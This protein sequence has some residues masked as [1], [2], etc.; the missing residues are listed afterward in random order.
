MLKCGLLGE[1]LGHSYSPMIHAQLADYSYQLYERSPEQLTPFLRSTEWDGLNVTI[2]YKK[3][4]VPYCDELS[5]QARQLGSVNTL[6]RLLGGRLYGDN[7]DYYGF[8]CLVNDSGIQVAGRSAIVLG[9]GGA[10]VTVCAVLHA[11]G[12]ESVTVISRSG[13]DNYQNLDRH[14]DAQIVVNTTPLGMYPNNGEAAVD[15]RRFPKCEGVF[16]LIYNPARTALLLQAEELGIPC[17]CGL[18][19]LVAQAVR[20]CERFTGSVID[21]SQIDEI[22]HLM[23]AQLQNIVLIGMPGCGKSTVAAALGKRLHRPVYESDAMVE[24]R[25]GMSIS[26]IFARSGEDRFRELESEV[27]SELGKLTGAVISTG[28]GCVTRTENYPLLHQNGQ[29]FWLKR[30]LDELP[31]EG[32]PLSQRYSVEELFARREPLYERFADRMIENNRSA[33]QTAERIEENLL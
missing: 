26:E 1:K 29:I 9:N 8:S 16:D 13:E 27:L 11:M 18:K 22:E 5:P 23:R 28:G 31:V 24:Q 19:M 21:A 17:R 14:A 33:E 32:R 6:V 10:S 25:A 7:T 30:P 2:P 3:A 12:A 4:V 15:L 20:S